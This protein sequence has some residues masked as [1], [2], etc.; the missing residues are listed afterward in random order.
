MDSLTFRQLLGR[1]AT[2]VTVITTDAGGLLHGMTAS[3]VCSLSLEPPLLLVCVDRSTHCHPQL[4]A[5]GHFG[6]N[7]LSASQRE[8]SDLFARSQPPERGALRGAGYGPGPHGVPL[9]DGAIAKIVC[10]LETTYPG[11]DHDIFVGEV[12]EGAFSDDGD[13]EPLLYFRGMYRRIG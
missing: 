8:L 2:G 9:L 5:A 6:V 11:G 1:F 4:H 7:V 13:D 12:L 10:R 3:A